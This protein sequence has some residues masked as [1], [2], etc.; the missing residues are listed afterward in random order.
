MN[1]G[2]GSKS[3]SKPNKKI[4]EPEPGLVLTLSSWYKTSSNLDSSRFSQDFF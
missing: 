2:R 1:G 3:L 4:L